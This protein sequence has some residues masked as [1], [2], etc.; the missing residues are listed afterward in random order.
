MQIMKPALATINDVHNEKI[1]CVQ[2]CFNCCIDFPTRDT[3]I[4]GFIIRLILG[5]HD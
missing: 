1:W 2:D 3:K 5:R 4:T